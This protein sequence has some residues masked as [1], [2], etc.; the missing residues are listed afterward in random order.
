MSSQTLLVELFTEELPPKALQRLGDAFASGI[1]DGLLKRGLLDE[2]F[3]STTYATPRR[4]AVA[5]SLVR[6]MAADEAFTEKLMPVAVGIDKDGNAT[7]ALLKKLAAKS[8]GHVPVSQLSR[9]SDGKAEQLIYRGVA[10]GQALQFGLQKALD[11]AIHGLPIPKLMSYQLA[12]GMTTVQFVRPAH[13][14]VALH[15]EAIVPIKALGLDAGRTTH[16]HRFQGAKDIVLQQADEYENR[17]RNDGGVIASFEK[18]R[19]AIF[20][21]LLKRVAE[22]G[23]NLGDSQNYTALLDEVCALVE[24]PTVYVGKFD[25]EFLSVPAECL[26]LTMKL[27][28][29]YF[30]L[31]SA[32]GG[33]SSRFLIV[34]NMYLKDPRNVVEGNERVVRPRLSDARFFF[35]TD[36]KTKLIDRLPRLASVVYHNKLGSQGE[37]VARVSKLAASIALLINADGLLAERA[38]LLAK[39]DLVSDMVGEFPE[40]QGTMGRYYALHDGE[41][42]VVAD[43]IAEHYLP[44]FAGDKLPGSGVALAVALADKLETLAGL[45][46]I[47]QQPSGDK[48]P[49]A[50]RRHALGVLRMLLEKQLV[51]PL[52]KLVDAAF[53]AFPQGLLAD[54]RAELLAFLFERLR[55]QLREGGYTANEI[56]AVIGHLDLGVHIAPTL[57]RAVRLFAELPEATS[58]AAAN[59][60]IGNILKKSEQRFTSVDMALLVEP[61]E[62]SLFDAVRAARENFDPLYGANNYG[63]A[64]KSLAPLKASVDAFFDAVMVNAEDAKLRENRLA[65]LGDLHDLMNKIADLSKLAT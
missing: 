19:A 41:S 27:N 64:L 14:L 21:F 9:E 51:V 62:R 50:L 4:L 39:A 42:P 22:T 33:L 47:G 17:L 54:T 11:D 8:L 52:A 63:E 58:L 30:P 38:A 16:G 3:T 61:A 32:E 65:L 55:G 28:Q 13:G 26:V 1:V 37:R 56:E 18:R 48:D 53:A 60:R 6:E 10:K 40:L 43:A 7:P 2:G 23:D 15:G 57:L 12:D 31:Y 45:F 35:E 29:K 5:I 25:D 20:E 49:F 46:G 24:K 44:R 36:Q 34:S 59:K